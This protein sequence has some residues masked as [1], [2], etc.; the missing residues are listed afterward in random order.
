MFRCMRLMVTVRLGAIIPLP[1]GLMRN[2]WYPRGKAEYMTR[3]QLKE[4]DL[5]DSTIERDV[6]FMALEPSSKSQKGDSRNVGVK[7]ALLTAGFPKVFWLRSAFVRD[8]F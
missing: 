8:V 1:R 4:L 5:K 6:T 2:L 7:L 3:S